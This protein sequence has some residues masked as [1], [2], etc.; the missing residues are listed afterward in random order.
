MP[1]SIQSYSNGRR[2]GGGEEGDEPL[3]VFCIN[4]YKHGIT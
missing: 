4:E 1:I 2:I 3:N